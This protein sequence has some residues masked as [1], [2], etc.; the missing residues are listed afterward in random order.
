MRPKS[1]FSAALTPTETIYRCCVCATPGRAGSMKGWSTIITVDNFDKTK[2]KELP[3]CAD[4]ACV[5][6][7]KQWDITPKKKIEQQLFDMT[8]RPSLKKVHVDGKRKRK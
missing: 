1:I 4:P 2:T 8:F 5:E 3:V 7:A 6:H